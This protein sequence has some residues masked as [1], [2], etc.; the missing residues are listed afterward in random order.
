MK[1][2]LVA[3]ALLAAS[4]VALPFVS[5]EPYCQ[6]CPYSCDTLGL[7][8][9][10]CRRIESSQGLCCLDLNDKGMR[11]AKE[12]ASHHAGTKHA[13]AAQERCPAGFQ[14]SERK[15]TQEERRRGCKDV[16]LSNGIGCVKR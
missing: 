2:S 8:K 3:A 13:A 1:K 10:D 6:A 16:R 12:Y 4:F 7:S 15:C 9:K 14:Q 5:A 11:V